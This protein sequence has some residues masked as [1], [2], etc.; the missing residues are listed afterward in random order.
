M[1][2]PRAFSESSAPDKANLRSPKL[3][4]LTELDL[5]TLLAFA[6]E[7]A[8]RVVAELFALAGHEA[9]LE[10][11]REKAFEVRGSPN[12]GLQ[13]DAAEAPHA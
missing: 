1:L 5:S 8:I 9:F 7:V 11:L 10:Q 4:C 13:S 3:P 6:G 12:N 2:P